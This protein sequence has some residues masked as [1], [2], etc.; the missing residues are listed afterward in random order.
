MF[1]ELT[2]MSEKCFDDNQN[3]LDYLANGLFLYG[4]FR[5]FNYSKPFTIQVGIH[6]FNTNRKVAFLKAAKLFIRNSYTHI[7]TSMERHSGAI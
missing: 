6:S 3:Y 4:A 1:F 2:K 7:H 5:V